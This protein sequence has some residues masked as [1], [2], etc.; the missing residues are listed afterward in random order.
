VVLH[1]K[2]KARFKSAKQFHVLYDICKRLCKS[3]QNVFCANVRHAA[4]AN[5][6][7]LY[8]VRYY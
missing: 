2:K 4:N 1:I 7:Q 5:S 6:L 3:R 8:R